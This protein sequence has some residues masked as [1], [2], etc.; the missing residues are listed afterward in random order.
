[1]RTNNQT[2]PSILTLG[3]LFFLFCIAPAALAVTVTDTATPFTAGPVNPQNGFA[4]YVQDSGGLAL[5]M[6]LDSVDN[7]GTPPPCFFDPFVPGNAFS[8]Q[9]GFG[10]EG[11]WWAA[12]A[13]IDVPE[14]GFSA[15]LIQAVEAAF[16]TEEPIDGDQFPFTRL[17]IRVN[18]PQPGIYTLTHPYGQENYLIEAIGPGFEV[19]ESFDIEFNV[20]STNQ[21]RIAPFLRWDNSLPAPPAGYLGDAS[22]PH[23]ITG[24]PLG[25]NFF[26]IE[27]TDLNGG[28]IP[29]AADGSNLVSTDQFIVMGKIFTGV[30]PTPLAVDRTSYARDINGQVDVFATSAPTASVSIS[31]GAN[32][33]AS[34]TGLIGDGNGKFFAHIPLGDA[35]ILPMI[36]DVTATNSGNSPTLHKSQLV[37]VVTITKAEY[38]VTNGRLRIEAVSSDL[39]GAPVLSATGLGDLPLDVAVAAPSA[40][41]SVTS[42]AGGSASLPIS[43]V[44]AAV[45][46]N[47]APVA[48]DDTAS[49]NEGVAVSINLA[50]NDFDPND[51][52]GT[53][54]PSGSIDVASLTIGT[55]PGK[56]TLVNNNDGSVTYT[57][58][59]FFNGTDQFTYT[60]RDSSGAFSNV[61]TATVSVI[62]VNNPP[63]ATNDLATVNVGNSINIA[64][65]LNDTDVDN[66]LDPA[67]LT[68]G[69]LPTLGNATVQAN[70]TVSYAAGL[71]AGTDS[72]TYTVSDTTGAASNLATVTVTVTNVLAETISVQKAQFKSDKNEW[73]IDGSS[74]V[75]GPGN[76]IDIHLGSDVQGAL[77][78]T[79]EVDSLG[80]WR[81]KESDSSVTA[82]GATQ[83]TVHSTN[84][85]TT[86]AP[87]Q[88]R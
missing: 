14:T 40:K 52:V 48:V 51:L 63:Q 4:L 86:T 38:D 82:N 3:I 71:S 49:T 46:G 73:R 39:T 22:T 72:F 26:Q 15:I 37:D 66:N 32:L 64:V 68:L 19:R 35:S 31:G 85:A 28:P 23:T 61:A 44:T 12:D 7:L 62:G 6:C 83:I 60:V 21:G 13:F 45:P 36:V 47:L 50:A 65:L 79:I 25:T 58:T 76:F 87:L 54:P 33:P 69:T 20:A 27:G 29:L 59:A 16:L 84:G 17:R 11:F 88:A 8:E 43:I 53:F 78:G 80:T 1:M 24:S 81:F 74:T 56:G 41:A 57:P 30:A 55:A 10:A 2:K 67:S 77:I 5:E 18:V 70:G 9:I 34:A 75:P 42:A